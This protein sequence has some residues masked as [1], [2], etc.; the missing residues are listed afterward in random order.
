MAYV[1]LCAP[2]PPIS[3]SLFYLQNISVS[4]FSSYP[5]ILLSLF[6]VNARVHMRQANTPR[7][8]TSANKPTN[9]LCHVNTRVVMS[10]NRKSWLDPAIR[11]YSPQKFALKSSERFGGNASVYARS[12]TA[13]SIDN[14]TANG[15]RCKMH[16]RV[17]TSA[18]LDWRM[19]LFPLSLSLLCDRFGELTIEIH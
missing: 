12:L 18:V 19:G 9:Q 4:F 11:E 8:V 13:L 16:R 1:C 17:L 2:P 3:F 5:C 10:L 15:S 14:S 6:R 7:F